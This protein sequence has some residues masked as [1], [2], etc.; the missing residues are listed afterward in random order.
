MKRSILMP[1]LALMFFACSEETDLPG[2]QGDDFPNI[3]STFA[4]SIDLDEPDNYA[5]QDIPG[6]IAKDNTRDNPITDKGATL[7]RVLFYDVNLSVDNSVSCS[8]CHRQAFAFGDID[9]ASTGVDGT[10]ARHSMRLINSR[11]SVEE[12]F[13]WDER[14]ATLEEQTT[15]PIQDHVEMGFSGQNG[16]PDIHDLI[17]KLEQIDY[18]PEFFEWV[19]GTPEITE[20]RMQ[21]ALAQ[22]VRSIQSFDSKYDAGR[23]QSPNDAAPFANFSQDEN[24]GKQLFLAPPQLDANGNRIAGGAGC[25][26]CHQ[27]PEFDIDPNSQNNGIIGVLGAPGQTDLTVTRA[28]SLRDIVNT[29]GVLNGGLM[30][31]AVFDQSLIGVINHYDNLPAASLNP[32]LDIRLRAG[33]NPRNLQ[34]TNQEKQQLVAFLETLAGTNVYTDPKWGDPF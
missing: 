1:V 20:E 21:N 17:E 26:G 7:G 28:P 14:A 34:L 30:H 16:N 24:A 6:Y 5:N 31:T 13:F 12:Q 3:R 29:A 10:T 9:A 22:F 4:H 18:Y 2:N 25:A 32:Q 33:Q 23:G 19:Y 11:F 8:G 15:M 27:P